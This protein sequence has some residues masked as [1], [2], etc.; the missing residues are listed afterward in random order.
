MHLSTVDMH[1]LSKECFEAL[2][3]VCDQASR[4][5]DDAHIV[6]RKE[7]LMEL[8]QK[9]MQVYSTEVHC[10]SMGVHPKNRDGEGFKLARSQQNG[11]KLKKQG[12]SSNVLKNDTIAVEDHPID[13]HVA[14]HTMKECEVQPDMARYK[15]DEIK[16]GPLGA[17]HANG[18]FACVHDQTPCKIPSISEDGKMS[19]SKCFADTGI[20]K[21]VN[22]GVVWQVWKWQVEAA[23]PMVPV[24]IQRALNATAQLA[25]GES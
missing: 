21:A 13:K 20:E 7:E 1:G 22:S 5:P 6:A 17:T 9:Y 14:H 19:L 23:L 24:I 2:K 12:F 3:H 4:D 10:K 18:F 15:L 16:Y 11:A 8:G 25:A